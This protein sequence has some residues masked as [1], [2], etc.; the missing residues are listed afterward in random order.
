MVERDRANRAELGQVILE[1]VV[2]AMPGDNIVR[3]MVLLVLKHFAHEPVDNCPLLAL[4]CVESG[5]WGAEVPLVGQAIGADR[6]QVRDRKMPLEQLSEPTTTLLAFNVHG[7]LAAPGHNDDLFGWD[8]QQAELSR[9]EQRAG[10]GHNEHVAVGGVEGDTTARHI[11]PY[12]VVVDAQARLQ[13][14]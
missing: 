14:R 11:L 9:D 7:E 12:G 10:L 1:G 3:A 8:A 2:V 6:P 5:H 13:V 4:A